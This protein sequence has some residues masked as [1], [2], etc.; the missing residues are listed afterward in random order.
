MD[1]TMV[2]AA[3]DR[4]QKQLGELEEIFTKIRDAIWF[5]TSVPDF[6]GIKKDE[7]VLALFT[8]LRAVCRDRIIQIIDQPSVDWKVIYQRANSLRDTIHEPHHLA[9]LFYYDLSV[10]GLPS[11]LRLL[12]PLR[13]LIKLDLNTAYTYGELLN[14]IK[15]HPIGEKVFKQLADEG[16]SEH[17]AFL[18]VVDD[19]RLGPKKKKIGR[20]RSRWPQKFS[21]EDLQQEAKLGAWEYWHKVKAPIADEIQLPQS[22][23]PLP[24]ERNALWRTL[25]PIFAKVEAKAW[26]EPLLPIVRGEWDRLPDKAYQA[27]KNLWEKQKAQKR[28][29]IEWLYREEAFDENPYTGNKTASKE[30]TA[31]A[32]KI[33]DEWHQKTLVE[34]RV[35]EVIRTAKKHIGIKAAEAFEH[36]VKVD[37]EKEAAKLAGISERTYRNYVR[38]VK[39]ILESN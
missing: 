27:L 34:D 2:D 12:Q 38:E 23:V 37:T 14:R 35:D 3:I 9:A 28:D 26:A 25:N 5:N 6:S 33:I 29:G 11:S 1:Q 13:S 24:A 39:E 10:N 15:N 7:D 4:F 31:E 18:E 32:Q 30:P 36:R 20:I 17:E 22:P 8:V 19:L 16:K 21:N